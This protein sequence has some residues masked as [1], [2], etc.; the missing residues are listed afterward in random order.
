MLEET[1]L[2]IS[3]LRLLPRIYS[4]PHRDSRRHTAGVVFLGRADGSLLA[5]DDAAGAEVISIPTLKSMI[6]SER[7]SEQRPNL[8]F[9][10]SRILGDYLSS[11]LSAL[12][13]SEMKT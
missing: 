1:S 6:A 5:G 7:A 9:D 13:P 2:R 10:H 8:D 12:S 4:D 11:G 3:H